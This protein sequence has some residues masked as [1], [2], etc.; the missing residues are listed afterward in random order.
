MFQYSAKPP[1]RA[2]FACVVMI[3]SYILLITFVSSVYQAMLK[4]TN[5]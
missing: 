3:Y 1:K 5:P 2:D 4:R